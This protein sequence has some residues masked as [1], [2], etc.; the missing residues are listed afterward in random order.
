MCVFMYTCVFH[1]THMEARGQRFGSQL[2]LFTVG[3]GDQTQVTRPGSKGP[4]I[5]SRLFSSPINIRNCVL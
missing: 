2:S 4:Y 1:G 5:L 3:P